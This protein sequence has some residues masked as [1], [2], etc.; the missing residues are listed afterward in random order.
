LELAPHFTAAL[1]ATALSF[2]S[3]SLTTSRS[4]S[5]V[6]NVGDDASS[7]HLDLSA[8]ARLHVE[9][10][11]LRAAGSGRVGVAVEINGD[12]CGRVSHYEKFEASAACIADVESGE[13]SV[14]LVTNSASSS[15]PR[16]TLCVLALPR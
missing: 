11:A 14:N 1:G 12:E 3:F 6:C 8:P 5:G 15:S 2:G 13:Y 9:A 4:E 7:I 16:Y 10:S